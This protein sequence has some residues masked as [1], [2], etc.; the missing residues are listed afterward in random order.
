MLK[1]LSIELLI[2]IEINKNI[3]G[4]KTD[5]LSVIIVTGIIYAIL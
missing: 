1:F 5:I 4:I 3:F 2:S